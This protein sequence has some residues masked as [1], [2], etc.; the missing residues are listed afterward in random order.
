VTGH[1][2]VGARRWRCPRPGRRGGTL[3][4]RQR[5]AHS[6]E[7]VLIGAALLQAYDPAWWRT[8]TAAPI[9]LLTLDM[10]DPR[11]S[12]L[13]QW[14]AHIGATI[15]ED[16][17]AWPVPPYVQAMTWL[18]ITPGEAAGYGFTGDGPAALSSEW[19]D[20]ISRMRDPG[21]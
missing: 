4:P 2:R 9:D 14:A 19:R 10:S 8:D 3:T 16:P 18:G 11:S 21:G 20:L 6:L 1:P 12:I 13:G 15:G 17:R 5:R 7:G